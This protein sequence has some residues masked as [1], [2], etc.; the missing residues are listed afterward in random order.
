M[1]RVIF[2]YFLSLHVGG[3]QAQKATVSGYIRDADSGETL[4]GANVYSVQT[5]QQF[6]G[7]TSNS[8]GF[9]SLTLNGDSA[10]L[11]FSYVGFQP[12]PVKFKL[13]RDTVIVAA[14]PSVVLNEV[15][16]RADRAEEIQKTTRMSTLTVPVDQ[17]KRLPAMMGEVDVVKVLQLLPG[18]Q[19]GSEGSTGLYVRGGGPDQNLLLLDGVPIYNAS[20][21]FGFFSTFNADAIHHVELVKGGFPARYGGRL[22]SVVDISLK[23]GNAHALHGQATVG[24]IAAKAMLEGPIKKDKTSF[25]VSFRR[26][27]LNFIQSWGMYKAAGPIVNNYFFYDLNAKINHKINTRNRIYLSVYNGQDKAD[28]DT[29]AQYSDANVELSTASLSSLGW[30]N[31]VSALRWNHVFH[32][33]LFANISATYSQYDFRVLNETTRT[34]YRPATQVTELQFYKSDYRSGITDWATKI[35]FD[36][37]PNPAHYV[38][39]G[40]HGIQHDFAPGVLALK[41]SKP[42]G[43]TPNTTTNIGAIELSAYMED[44]WAITEKIKV[45]A[46]VHASTFLV[47]GKS[48]PSLQPRLSSRF[49]LSPDWSL[50]ASYSAMQQNIHLLSNA[51]IGL[52][53]DLWVPA[54]KAIRPQTANQAALGFAYNMRNDYEISVEGYYKNMK[55]VIEY[56]DGASYLSAG[57]DWQTKVETGTGESYGAEL[58]IQKKVG[59]INGWVGYTLAW[60][61]R[62]F[63]NLNE[64]MPFPYRYDRRHDAKIVISYL[65]DERFNFGLTW[66]YGTGNAVTVPLVSYANSALPLSSV[67]DNRNVWIY[68]SRN[69]FRM[70]DYHK[71]DLSA[72]Y[73]IVRN[74]LKHSFN[75][76]V[77][78]AYARKNP[79]YLELQSLEP[80][81]QKALIQVSLF[82]IV[83][84]LSYS[85][86]F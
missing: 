22:S 45:N 70:G 5:G 64:G 15:V 27:Y 52:P 44:D 33:K 42:I 29:E 50:K 54:T 38:R 31:L 32:D 57:Q 72:T 40:V 9:Y 20:H 63:A 69:G 36:F 79:F 25:L 60:N 2:I 8:Y 51:G 68:S 23:D 80:T 30:G 86:Q 55:N 6:T 47:E 19:G 4:I 77:Y 65:P 58:F 13:T 34:D 83:P 66:V 78:N 73:T 61:N 35:D 16:V 7:T 10:S 24:I 48:Y 49:L 37:M 62:Q 43:A 14:L 67:P 21:F 1:W 71:L 82:S 84:S 85:I 59:K 76:S 41:S 11:V 75:L 17:L 18:V 39:F 81:F 56:K 12:L 46:G 53:T 28:T 74:R 3:V 26:S